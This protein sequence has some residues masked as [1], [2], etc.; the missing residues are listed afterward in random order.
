MRSHMTWDSGHGAKFQFQQA[1]D[2]NLTLKVDF[3]ELSTAN[4][5]YSPQ[6]PQQKFTFH[7]YTVQCY[8]GSRPSALLWGGVDKAPLSMYHGRSWYGDIA[9]PRKK[10][11]MFKRLI[12]KMGEHGDLKRVFYHLAFW[13]PFFNG[14]RTCMKVTSWCSPWRKRTTGHWS[15]STSG[16]GGPR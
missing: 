4:R 8:W 10:R 5:P 14:S 3:P 16:R 12:R 9:V 11:D 13:W 6:G 15:W 7:S 1:H 2:S